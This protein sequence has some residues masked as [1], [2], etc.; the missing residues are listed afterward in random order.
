MRW[1]SWNLCADSAWSADHGLC[2]QVVDF[3]SDTLEEFNQDVQCYLE[4]HR[5]LQRK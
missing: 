5:V 4:E 1:Y 2:L 3:E